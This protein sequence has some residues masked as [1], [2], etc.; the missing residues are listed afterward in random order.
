MKKAQTETI[1]LVAIVILVIFILII[2]IMFSAQPK[3]TTTIK[4]NVVVHNLLNAILKINPS[5]G[6]EI[7]NKQLYK[8]ISKGCPTNPCGTSDSCEIYVKEQL[9]EAVNAYLAGTDYKLNK[10]TISDPQIEINPEPDDCSKVIADEFPISDFV[11]TLE[12]C[13]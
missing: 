6:E 11:A 8:I 4:Q 1:G 9:E 12:L 2:Y 3:K 10:L 7:S 13:I 5:C